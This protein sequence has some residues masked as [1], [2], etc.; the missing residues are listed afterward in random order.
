MAEHG[1]GQPAKKWNH[2]AAIVRPEMLGQWD[3][4]KNPSLQYSTKPCK[5]GESG[6]AIRADARCV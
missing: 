4:E 6:G 5:T 1:N 2:Y 3:M